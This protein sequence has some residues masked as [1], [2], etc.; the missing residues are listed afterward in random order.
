MIDAEGTICGFTHVR[1][2]DGTTRTGVH[3]AITNSSIALLDNAQRIWPTSRAE[4]NRHGDGHLG[5]LDVYRWIAHGV[6][7]KAMLVRELYPYLIAKRTQALL[8]WNFFQMSINAKRLARTREAE[9]VKAKRAAIV[10]LMSRLNHAQP[11]DIPSWCEEPPPMYEPGYYLRSDIIWAK[12]NPMPESVTDRP[13]KAHEYMFLLTKSPS[14]YYDADAI[15]EENSPLT[16]KVHGPGKYETSDGTSK[17][18]DGL[19][20]Q[21]RD[22]NR[23]D[24]SSGLRNGREL[25]GRN[26]RSVWTVATQPYSGAHFATFPP[27]LI[28]PCILAGSAK[29]ACE[30]CGAAWVRVV[31]RGEDPLYV[32]LAERRPNGATQPGNATVK[33]GTFGNGRPTLSQSFTPG[34][35][36]PDNHGT[37]CSVVLDP[38]GGAGTTGLVADRLGRDAI[39]IELNPAYAAL[40]SDRITDDCP[41]FVNVS[42]ADGA[43]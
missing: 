30:H 13:T 7:S 24:P 5:G 14:Y 10:E 27:A 4:H 3:I 23:D 33:T 39:L 31:E 38:F 11:V 42:S 40:G 2:D 36:C 16:V 25:N 18:M 20:G 35:E 37:A 17:P 34:C 43:A 29:Q 21:R 1:K 22:W 6:E 41:L 19:R 12:P 28:E 8:A 32:P 9:T 26:R 15:K